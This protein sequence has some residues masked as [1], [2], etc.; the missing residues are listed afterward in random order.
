MRFV[1]V[2]DEASKDELLQRGFALLKED[3][4][5]SLWVFE[6]KEPYA[7]E[8]E[9]IECPHVLSDTLTF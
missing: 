4:K 7:F 1:Y 3:T 9:G 5:N 2:M 6:N 8:L